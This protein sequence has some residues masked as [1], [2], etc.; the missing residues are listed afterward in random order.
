MDVLS[1]IL[2]IILGLS[3]IYLYLENRKLKGFEIGRDIKLK[4]IEIEEL[5]RLSNEFCLDKDVWHMRQN[6]LIKSNIEL[7]HLKRL[8]K[9]RWIFSK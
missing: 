9:Y 8:K 5:F 7:K 6:N 1:K 3:A 4:E 2:N